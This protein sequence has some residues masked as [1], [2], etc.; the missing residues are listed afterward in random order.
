MKTAVVIKHVAFEDLGSWESL[1]NKHYQIKYIDAVDVVRNQ[2]KNEEIDLLVILGGPISVYQEEEYPFI[3]TIVDLLERRLNLD[4]PTLG[5]CLGSQF[6]ARALGSKVYPNHTKEIGWY[7][8]HLTEKGK[9]SCIKD[10]SAEHTSMFH[11]HG[12]TFDLPKGAE[13]LAS[14]AACTNQ[15][16]SWKKNGLAFQCHPEVIANRL[17]HWW[18]GHASEVAQNKLNLAELRKES[19]KWAPQLEKQSRRCL[20]AWFS[21]M[22]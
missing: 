3:T 7:P 8:L 5:V 19:A 21:Q 1:L 14:S 6:M 20:E 22:D 17:E 9:E 15:I 2:L 11:W 18:I 16:F 10:L 4:L 13:L 12:D